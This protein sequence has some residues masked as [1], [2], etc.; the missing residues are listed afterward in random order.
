[1]IILLIKLNSDPTCID[2]L[3]DDGINKIF[4]SF[5]EVDSWLFENN[6]TE[7]EYKPI[8][9]EK[10]IDLKKKLDFFINNNF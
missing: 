10:D 7:N 8:I 5:D 6:L 1:M 2:F 4:H 9:I 3:K